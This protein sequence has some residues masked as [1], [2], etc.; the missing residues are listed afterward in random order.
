MYWDL[1]NRIQIYLLSCNSIKFIPLSRVGPNT[2]CSFSITEQFHRSLRNW[3]WH[4]SMAFLAPSDTEYIA[5]G[6]FRHTLTCL[7]ARPGRAPQ[8]ARAWTI[9]GSSTSEPGEACCC[10]RG[11]GI[12]IIPKY[13]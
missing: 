10:W 12:P 3:T 1:I 5:F 9:S 13:L 11:G 6:C 7:D 4:C 2:L 8:T